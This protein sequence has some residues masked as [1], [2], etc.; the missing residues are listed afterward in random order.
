MTSKLEPNFTIVEQILFRDYIARP[1]LLAEL[2]VNTKIVYT[3]LSQT[4]LIVK[5]IACTKLNGGL[6][7][8]T[9]AN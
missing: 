7:L 2:I 5:D 9:N 4:K 1:K 8:L 6:P 3:L